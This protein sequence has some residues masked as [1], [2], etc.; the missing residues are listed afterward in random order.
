MCKA[1]LQ[2]TVVRLVLAKY[3]TLEHIEPIGRS[4]E[5]PGRRG[6]AE[7]RDYACFETSSNNLK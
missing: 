3:F 4:V 5:A 6:E 1:E 7:K 2:C